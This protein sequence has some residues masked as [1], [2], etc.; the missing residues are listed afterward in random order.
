MQNDTLEETP[1]LSA[2][3]DKLIHPDYYIFF[4]RSKDNRYWTQSKL[5]L[6]NSSWLQHWPSKQISST[7]T[8]TTHRSVWKHLLSETW[9]STLLECSASKM[10][11]G[12][13]WLNQCI[14]NLHKENQERTQFSDKNHVYCFEDD[15]KIKAIYSAKISAVID[16]HTV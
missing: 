14:K 10:V 9:S 8:T 7:T 15:R 2:G 5:I 12:N 4:N 6:A 13:K 1:V 11:C 3:Y 16:S